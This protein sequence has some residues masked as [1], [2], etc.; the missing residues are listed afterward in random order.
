M[1]SSPQ[2]D[3][4]RLQMAYLAV[5]GDEK[6]RT[7]D[8]RLVWRDLES[9]CRAYRLSCES[10]TDGEYALNNTLVNEGRRSVWIRALGQVLAAIAPPPERPMIS[11][12]R[13][14]TSNS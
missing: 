3:Q 5:F 13:K 11:R 7:A 8:Q 2:L 12:Q 4:R 10:L 6:S 14:P 1:A 9:F